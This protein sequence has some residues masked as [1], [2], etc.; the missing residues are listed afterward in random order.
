LSIKD[1]PV[2]A[3][4]CSEGLVLKTG[5]VFAQ[6]GFKKGRRD[7]NQYIK[8]KDNDL[9]IIVVY[10]DDIIFGTS[11]ELMS[12]KFIDAMKQEFHMSMLGEISLFLGLQIHQSKKRIFIYESKYLKEI[13]KRFGIGNYTLAS[14]HMT[15]IFKVRKYYDAT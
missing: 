8:A 1:N 10:A 11:I 12:K 14:T 2:W 7:R 9:L 15:T 13:L 3:K 4:T 5:Q 6:K